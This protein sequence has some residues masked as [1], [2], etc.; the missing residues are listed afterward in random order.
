MKVKLSDDKALK[1]IILLCPLMGKTN[2]YSVA[3]SYLELKIKWLKRKMEGAQCEIEQTQSIEALH[4]KSKLKQR[5]DETVERMRI[6]QA[7]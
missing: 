4:K 1:T 3:M 5:L 2:C 7:L 6:I